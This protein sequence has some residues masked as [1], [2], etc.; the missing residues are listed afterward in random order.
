M[1]RRTFHLLQSIAFG[2][3]TLFSASIPFWADLDDTGI[4]LALGMASAFGFMAYRNAQQMQNAGNEEMAYAPPKDASDTERTS[5]YKR[6]IYIS[7]VAFP[8]LTLLTISDLN[9]LESGATESALVW[10]PIAFVYEQ[11]GYWA[12]V[13]LIPLAGIAV[14]SL[15]YRKMKEQPDRTS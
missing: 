4:F 9:D 2:L 5:F 15:L 6:Y 8:L 1:D 3:L 10:G 13:L 11:F 14:I 12:A 7:L